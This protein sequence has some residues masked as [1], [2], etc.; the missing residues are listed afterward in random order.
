M[1]YYSWRPISL[2][3]RKWIL[4]ESNFSSCLE[5]SIAP[6]IFNLIYAALVVRQHQFD[7]YMLAKQHSILSSI[8]ASQTRT[9]RFQVI[10]RL[11]MFLCCGGC[12]SSFSKSHNIVDDNKENSFYGARDYK[13]IW[14]KI[15]AT[16]TLQGACLVYR[17]FLLANKSAKNVF[18]FVH[19][20]RADSVQIAFKM[21]INCL[22]IKANKRKKVLFHS[23][24]APAINN[25]T[26]IDWRICFS[27][28]LNVT[29]FE[30]VKRNF[31]DC[32]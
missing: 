32:S 6:A 17:F 23:A 19:F 8:I 25:R 4:I 31:S 26:R 10:A 22:T 20:S 18:S 28:I 7:N 12:S 14:V 29:F 3:G 15:K 13:V 5:C 27:I 1:R 2:M 30:G 9:S 16:N 21:G 11:K 24:E